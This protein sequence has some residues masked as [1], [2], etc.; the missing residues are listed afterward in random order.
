MAYANCD[1]V[2]EDLAFGRREKGE[3][4]LAGGGGLF[5]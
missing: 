2:K 5:H 1:M 3:K 4:G